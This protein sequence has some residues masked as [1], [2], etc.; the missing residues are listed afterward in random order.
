MDVLIVLAPIA[1][2]VALVLYFADRL[3]EAVRGTARAV[4]VSSFLISVVFIGFDPENLGVG[5]V[6]TYE[7]VVGIALG[8]IIGAAMV[9]IALA[10]GITALLAPLEFEQAPK[11]I[12][13]LPVLAVLLFGL[14]ALDGRISRPDGAVLLAGYAV[15]VT[16][17]LFLDRRGAIISGPSGEGPESNASVDSYDSND[18]MNRWKA[19]GLLALSLGGIAAGSTL[20]VG[21]SETI[22]ERL[23]I[24][25]TLYGMTILAFVISV[26]E[27]AREA[28]AALRGQPEI[29]LGNVVGSAL[30]FFLMNAGVIALVRPIP[31][32]AAVLRFHLPMAIVTTVYVAG[33]VVLT[34]R[35]SRRAGLVL[36]IAYSA[37]VVGSYFVESAGAGW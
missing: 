8:S 28:P 27:V 9:A 15:A 14:V 6:G 10:L 34:R 26:E 11:R 7:G 32:E 3:V 13:A 36:V 5:A 31:V 37:F 18:R 1:V 12:L 35:V 30:A 33:I 25:D 2:G 16:S 17:V 4:G 21:G 19:F 23:G 20:I 22:I 24:T 29:S